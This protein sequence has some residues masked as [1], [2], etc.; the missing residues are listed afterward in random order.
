MAKPDSHDEAKAGSGKRAPGAPTSDTLKT[1]R[2]LSPTILTVIVGAFVV[3]VV[4]FL[5]SNPG[6]PG[7]ESGVGRYG[8]SLPEQGVAPT[9]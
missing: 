3:M 2:S 9:P 6:G 7:A 4:L 5:V 8:Q 1:K